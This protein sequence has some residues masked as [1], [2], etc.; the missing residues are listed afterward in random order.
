MDIKFLDVLSCL[1]PILSFQPQL[2][3]SSYQLHGNLP[4]VTTPALIP[5]N[6]ADLP[7]H[8]AALRLV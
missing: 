1:S 4:L 8:K 5:G 3:H 7:W 6:E 2:M